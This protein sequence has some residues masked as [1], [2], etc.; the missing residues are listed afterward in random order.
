MDWKKEAAAAV[1]RVQLNEGPIFNA[2]FGKRPEPG[3]AYK[4]SA[5]IPQE[6]PATPAP[7]PVDPFKSVKDFQIA[8]HHQPIVAHVKTMLSLAKESDAMGKSDDDHLP[9]LEK[10]YTGYNGDY[11]FEGFHSN[12][13]TAGALGAAVLR[14]HAGLPA[15]DDHQDNFLHSVHMGEDGKL[16]ARYVSND[17]YMKTKYVK[18]L[19]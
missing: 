8:G 14:N 17:R 4:K 12:E 3:A 10:Y 1:D 19:E 15:A 5:G 7:P 13:D 16:K 11:H 9:K 2:I 6:A 18:D